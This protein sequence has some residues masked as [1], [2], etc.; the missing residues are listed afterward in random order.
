MGMKIAIFSHLTVVGALGCNGRFFLLAS[1]HLA[2]TPCIKL[3]QTVQVQRFVKGCGSSVEFLC[4][5]LQKGQKDSIKVYTRNAVI[6][7]TLFV[8]VMFSVCVGMRQQCKSHVTD[9]ENNL[10]FTSM[11]GSE[12][13]SL[14]SDLK[15]F[16]VI[17]F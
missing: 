4:W 8:E 7:T 2:S 13:H 12:V 9:F 6:S 15:I 16:L 11:V 17:Y 3:V 1:R 10:S 14:W 5:R